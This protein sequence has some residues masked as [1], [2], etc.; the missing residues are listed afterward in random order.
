MATKLKSVDAVVV[1]VGWVGS[2]MAHELTKA[3]KQVVGLERGAYRDTQPDFQVPGIHDELKYGIQYGLMQNMAKETITFRNT[4]GELALPYRHMGSFL[5]GDGVGGAGVHWNG[6]TYRWL[7]YDFEIKSQTVQRYGKGAVPEN[8]TIQDWGVTYADMEP[9]YDRFEYLCGISGQAG[10]IKGQKQPVGNPFEGSRSREYPLPPLLTPVS[11]QVFENAARRLG[12]HPFSIPAANTSETY[13]N[14]EGVSMGACNYCGYCERFACHMS[15]KSSPQTTVLPK[16]MENKNFELRTHSNVTRVNLDSAGKKAVSVTYVDSLGR[17]FEQPAD[18]IVLSSWV[19][20]N[21]RLLL[22]SDI[23]TPYDP[24]TGKGVV[25]RNYTYQSGAA[26]VSL[27]YEDRQ[28]HRYLGA[29]SAGI[30]IDDYN[31]DNFDHTGLNFIHGGSISLANTGARPIQSHPTPAGTPAWG[32]DFKKAM[33]KYYDRIIGVGTQAAVMPY[34]QN[35]LDLDPTYKD[36]F[37]NP[38]LR[39]TF[40]WGP[41]EHNTAT[42]MGG[43]MEKIAKEMKPSSYKVST[44]GAHYS[45]VPYQ[46]THNIGGAI[47]GADPSTS[48]VNTYMQNWDVPNL[49]VV[50]ASAFPH[51]SGYNPTATVG[52]FAYRAADAVKRYFKAPGLLT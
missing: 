1:G 29:G 44:L 30:V 8:S 51:N 34:R 21:V 49:F 41:N 27:V 46:S 31:G 18:V 52:A 10:N 33:V 9:Y 23:S 4:G 36:A 32:G 25:G 35:Y 38:M 5:P 2:I 48:V 26:S 6:M 24:Q 37:G 42:Y 17:E 45:V 7:P 39:M 40:D 19:F 16:L 28:F 20:N 15:A 47:M 43:V 50:G 11:S 22:M 3:G 13:T 12:Y 14:P